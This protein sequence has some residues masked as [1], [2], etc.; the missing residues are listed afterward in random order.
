MQGILIDIMEE[1][2]HERLQIPIT[3]TGY[4][5]A[6]AQMQVQ[7]KRADGFVTVPT[8]ERLSYTKAGTESVISLKNNLY[9]YAGHPQTDKLSQIKSPQELRDYKIADYIGNGWA[10]ETFKNI[11]VLWLPN[12]DQ[13]FGMLNQKRIDAVSSDQHTAIRYLKELRIQKN[14]IELP[15]TFKQSDFHLCIR[16]DSPYVNIIP[17]FDQTIKQMKQDGTLQKILDRYL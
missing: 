16:K 12:Q 7:A 10:K 5:W 6:R 1:A 9:T 17:Q 13:V 2:L 3:Q 8:K 15:V 11:D 14:I 4:P